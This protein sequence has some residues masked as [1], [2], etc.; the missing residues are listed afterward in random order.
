MVL[1][2]Q[3]H[4]E[5]LRAYGAKIE[6]CWRYCISRI[7]AIAIFGV[8]GSTA[9]AAND[10]DRENLRKEAWVA[11]QMA[12]IEKDPRLYLQYQKALTSDFFRRENRLL[13]E[14]Y[15]PRLGDA[16]QQLGKS[17]WDF[18]KSDEVDLILSTGSLL[19]GKGG[20]IGKTVSV[21]KNLKDYGIKVEN[22][23]NKWEREDA[24]KFVSLVREDLEVVL[25]EV[26]EKSNKL[27][28]K[29]A[30]KGYRPDFL[31]DTDK[32]GKRFS[33]TAP[34]A[35]DQQIFASAPTGVVAVK[36]YEALS[37][38]S[39]AQL[40]RL[41]GDREEFKKF[42]SEELG[43]QK[44]LLESMTSEMSAMQTS[45]TELIEARRAQETAEKLAKRQAQFDLKYTRAHEYTY[46]AAAALQ[47]V[48]PQMAAFV[49]NGGSAMLVMARSIES[50]AKD[51]FSA[52]ATGNLLGA[53][54]TVYSLFSTQGEDPTTAAMM[55]QFE[56]LSK[57]I[58]S[59]SK[60][61]EGI[62]KKIDQFIQTQNSGYADV[63]D[64]LRTLTTE[65]R[66]LQTFVID[67]ENTRIQAEINTADLICSDR[68]AS[69]LFSVDNP[70]SIDTFHQCLWKMYSFG[71]IESSKPSIAYSAFADNPAGKSE[72]NL[73]KPKLIRGDDLE[74]MISGL[75]FLERYAAKHLDIK[76]ATPA[77][78]SFSKPFNANAVDKAQIFSPRLWS[79]AVRSLIA[80]RLGFSEYSPPPNT[81]SSK[82]LI[83]LAEIG[84]WMAERVNI[85]S[86]DKM[87]YAAM[88]R[89]RSRAMEVAKLSEKIMQAD[90]AQRYPATF[91]A[92]RLGSDLKNYLDLPVSYFLGYE[93]DR[94]W[95]VN[96]FSSESMRD[97][98]SLAGLID[99]LTV[100]TTAVQ[101][102]GEPE[103]G[104]GKVYCF[105][106]ESKIFLQV[107][108]RVD[109]GKV[110]VNS[111][112]ALTDGGLTGLV[113]VKNIHKS[114][115]DLAGY[116]AKFGYISPY[117]N[118]A[119][120]IPD[121][122]VSALKVDF[123]SRTLQRGIVKLDIVS[124]E[125]QAPSAEQLKKVLRAEAARVALAAHNKYFSSAADAPTST[126]AEA[127]TAVFEP[128]NEAYAAML[129]SL[130]ARHGSCG[131]WNP[132]LTSL[133]V[134]AVSELELDD[135][136][137]GKNILFGPEYWRRFSLTTDDGAVRLLPLRRNTAVPEKS[138]ET[139]VQSLATQPRTPSASSPDLYMRAREHFSNPPE[140]NTYRYCA[141]SGVPALVTGMR[142]ITRW[143]D[144]M[145][146]GSGRILALKDQSVES[147]E[148]I[149]YKCSKK[150]VA[151]IFQNS[152]CPPGY[153]QSIVSR[154]M[155]N[156]GAPR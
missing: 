14:R 84:E 155:N 101:T 91:H 44:K 136:V 2:L 34:Y 108:P 16:V 3:V 70:T 105:R 71:I 55:A 111:C 131:N 21:V 93:T 72:L 106:A 61:I 43:G 124:E 152:T 42:L 59:L 154:G 6:R 79:V 50:L 127:R 51:G 144:L 18:A 65:L 25:R 87:I 114:A 28:A 38:K 99:V 135:Y 5:R 35:S 147:G 83:E 139:V 11:G 151:P 24:R 81:P 15:A 36:V 153:Q 146:F 64:Q 60:Q 123:N 102:A 58:T 54:F 13:N 89:Y 82:Y 141:E 94:D 126:R 23:N 8:A 145:D 22:I 78:R 150:G 57:Q 10:S 103:V 110:G 68:L 1:P 128:L 33:V 90:L 29:S 107:E 98:I 63:R 73:L 52:A 100:E 97:L 148:A 96:G 85:L 80:Y 4:C 48:D 76:T 62:D 115:V 133:R 67:N 122:Q 74:T 86:G 53:A 49:Q 32:I 116:F 39:D 149:V 121:D 30:G 17:A 20:A 41:L 9:T 132:N 75:S 143:N 137:D 129:L 66:M 112:G 7:L 47:F 125:Y 156:T 95:R 77:L 56:S 140:A 19:P 120:P 104:P 118:P 109:L 88:D 119:F 45:L 31:L 138:L 69:G 134:L 142:A 12:A 113:Q 92:A 26:Y 46:A 130:N 40:A 117:F 27:Q 37:K